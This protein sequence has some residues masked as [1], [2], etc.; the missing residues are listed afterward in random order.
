MQ[1]KDRILDI[2]KN[3]FESIEQLVKVD[4]KQSALMKNPKHIEL[5]EK[6]A[7]VLSNHYVSKFAGLTTSVVTIENGSKQIIDKYQLKMQ[8]IAEG[9]PKDMNA[10]LK[11]VKKYFGHAY[12]DDCITNVT[13]ECFLDDFTCEK[14]NFLTWTGNLEMNSENNLQSNEEKVTA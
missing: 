4:Y 7:K 14:E 5:V 3:T 11:S 2:L 10:T 13:K 12:S 8:Q 6:Y 9:F 1:T